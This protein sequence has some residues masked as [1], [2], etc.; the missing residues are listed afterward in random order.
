MQPA[1]SQRK[2]APILL[3][4]PA[5]VASARQTKVGAPYLAALLTP[6]SSTSR[7]ADPSTTTCTPARSKCHP[8]PSA[9]KFSVKAYPPLLAGNNRKRS[10]SA[11]LSSS[12][13]TGKNK[14]KRIKLVHGSKLASPPAS[15]G[16]KPSITRKYEAAMARCALVSPSR[17]RK[18]LD[19]LREMQSK[20]I[21]PSAHA[22]H[23]LVSACVS[24][25]QTALARSILKRMMLLR[26]EHDRRGDHRIYNAL[27][28]LC[29][30][31]SDAD[32]A[33]GLIQLMGQSSSVQITTGSVD[34]LLKVCDA[35][36][37][38]SHVQ[39]AIELFG[40]LQV[41]RGMKADRMLIDTMLQTCFSN[42]V[43]TNILALTREA[44]SI[45]MYKP[46]PLGT[47]GSMCVWDLHNTIEMDA[48][49]L[50]AEAF[51]RAAVHAAQGVVRDVVIV[52][53]KGLGSKNNAPVLRRKIPPFLRDTIGLKV[54][55]L[56][57][58]EG[59]LLITGNSLQEWASGSKYAQFRM[60]FG[61]TSTET[62]PKPPPS[63]YIPAAAT[64]VK[65]PE[66]KE[67]KQKR[68]LLAWRHKFAEMQRSGKM[69]L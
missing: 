60:L 21:R 57:D 26:T 33:F 15:I 27:M 58:N 65:R 2:T 47:A 7:G 13:D 68:R 62:K 4:T 63:T 34:I 49:F 56:K 32:A 69:W 19:I 18:S 20:G 28:K 1:S 42:Q 46:F 11:L 24:N 29:I 45:G 59:R 3:T 44:I 30:K 64:K 37:D 51:D 31:L 66:T 38:K 40:R 55:R 12:G 48:C 14:S 9:W 25:G 41:E 10:T 16:S 43:Y 67:E 53:G 8:A 22:F 35:V 5:L 17:L 23:G 61:R 39:E 6:R 52:T 50:L 36:G 54:T